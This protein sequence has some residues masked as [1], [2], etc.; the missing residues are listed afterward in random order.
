MIL[1]L[2]TF[3]ACFLML[4]LFR[5]FDKSNARITKLRRYSSKVL[6]DYKKMVEEENRKFADATIE[7]HVLIKKGNSLS[8]DLKNSFQEIETRVQNLNVEKLNLEKLERDLKIVSLAAEDVNEQIKFISSA[9]KDFS[10]I[11]EKISFLIENLDKIK[12]ESAIIIKNF[13]DQ[14]REKYRKTSEELSS[15]ILQFKEFIKREENDLINE[16]EG[17]VSQLSSSFIDSLNNLEEKLSNTGD[18]ILDGFQK[19]V[20]YIEKNI[21]EAINLN[22]KVSSLKGIIGKIEE[23][24]F[25]AVEEK[26]QNLNKSID[27]SFEKIDHEV[28]K[29]YSK[30]NQVE[31]SINDSKNRLTL[32]LETEVEKIKNDLKSINLET[33]TKKDELVQTVRAEAEEIKEKIEMFEDK[34]IEIENKIITAAEK[35]LKTLD[36]EYQEIELRFNN[37]SKKFNS[38]EEYFVNLLSHQTN[39]AKEEFSQIERRIV[40]LKKELVTYDTINNDLRLYKDSLQESQTE[41]NKLKNFLIAVDKEL[42]N[43]E[44]VILKNTEAVKKSES[45]T[46]TLEDKII[47]F[48]K[49]TDRSEKRI[50]KMNNRLEE[51]EENT[52]ILKARG[53]EIKEVKDKLNEIDSISLFIEKRIDQLYTMFQKMESL[54]NDLDQTD[55]KLKVM[56]SETDQKMKEFASFIKNI[57][58]NPIAKQIQLDR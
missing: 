26:T 23:D 34:Y 53:K 46:S 5:K 52:L 27:L 38:N 56:F 29:T 15:N 55:D 6:N 22:S 44:E 21:N 10:N 25:K 1:N 51:V 39:K 31:L 12:N 33:V 58:H 37:L 30:I 40:D 54:K 17:K 35:K 2:V 16:S 50:E 32:L 20:T 9:K 57:D 19:K 14:I 28:D 24:V 18:A 43:Y 11:A 8:S 48:Q 47:S 41:S 4:L 42:H 36:D 45:I 13:N 7:M 3:I 49:I